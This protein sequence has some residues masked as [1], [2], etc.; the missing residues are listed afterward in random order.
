MSECCAPLI[1]VADTSRAV[2]I[3]NVIQKKCRIHF[4]TTYKNEAGAVSADNEQ[5]GNKRKCVIQ[6]QCTKQ[7]WR[8]QNK[9]VKQKNWYENSISFFFW[10]YQCGQLWNTIY[11]MFN[12]HC[13]TE[14]NLL[15]F[16][17]LSFSIFDCF[18]PSIRA[19]FQ[20]DSMLLTLNIYSQ[21][22]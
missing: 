4:K 16:F 18:V 14:T 2:D 22:E 1:E 11:S 21:V 10:L 20:I 8:E 13:C 7:T 12:V 6:K 5:R 15:F 19:R 17:S 9:K 3:E